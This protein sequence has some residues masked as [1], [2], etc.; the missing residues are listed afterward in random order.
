M[1]K[2]IYY[3]GVLPAFFFAGSMAL[4]S[5][6][7]DDNIDIDDVDA[8]IGV[9]LDKFAVPLGQTNDIFI[10]DLLEL[11]DDDCIQLIKDDNDGKGK[12]IMVKNKDKKERVSLSSG[13]VGDYIFY[14]KGD[15]VKGADDI[16]IKPINYDINDSKTDDNFTVSINVNPISFDAP[17]TNF[18]A[19]QNL[20]T[21]GFN[22]S[23]DEMVL[24][25]SHAE[26]NTDVVIKLRTKDLKNA[27]IN[28]IR[29]AVFKLPSYMTMS[30]ESD[31]S[32][33]E[34]GSGL[35][36]NTLILNGIPTSDTDRV[37]KLKL[38]GLTGFINNMADIVDPANYLLLNKSSLEMNGSVDLDLTLNSSDIE[39]PYSG[40][41][42][43]FTAQVDLDRHI[44]ITEATG[45]FNPDIDLDNLGEIEIDKDVP[46]FLKDKEG[47]GDVDLTLSN[48][49]ITLDIE[50]NIDV[51]GLVNAKLIATYENEK[52]GK[53]TTK[54]LFIDDIIVNAHKGD[55]K[56]STKTTVYICRKAEGAPA[57]A[58]IIVKGPNSQQKHGKDEITDIAALLNKIPKTITFTCDAGAKT[59][60]TGTVKLGAHYKIKPAYHFS[61]PLALEA[62]SKIVYDDQT[63]GFYKDIED[64]DIDFRGKTTLEITGKATN[65]T[66]LSLTIDPTAIDVNGNPISGIKLTSVNEITA[67]GTSDILIKMEKDA[68]TDLKAVKFDGIKFKAHATSANATT[69]NKNTHT[70]KIE[71]LKV[72]ISGE[73]SID[74]DSKKK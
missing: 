7:T 6:S 48:P 13:N 72:N 18:T 2:R 31:I 22:G 45:K 41:T 57:G 56:S 53:T 16:T 74:A 65:N 73:L 15:D 63:D 33:L 30:L 42:V 66:P 24:E 8:T 23:K 58:Q 64:N 10:D 44:T 62:G 67:N 38:T 70:I 19:Q 52:T 21:F 51:V 4:T 37:I 43:S 69:L 17:P 61:A 32:D 12:Y 49:T 25:L 3:L 59:D 14:K 50:N 9:K 28:K 71:N 46:D 54:T 29:K 34:E 11:N 40:G 60:E 39:L 36:G 47:K 55:I 68:N 26:A 1:K 20:K 27:K 35:V 5:C